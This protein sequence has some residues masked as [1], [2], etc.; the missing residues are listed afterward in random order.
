MEVVRFLPK[1]LSYLTNSKKVS[2]RE[3]GKVRYLSSWKVIEV[4]HLFLFQYFTRHK[5]KLELN[6]QVLKG[7][8]GNEY[9]YVLRYLIDI[10][11]IK[12][13]SKYIP[14][15]KSQSYVLRRNIRESEMIEAKVSKPKTAGKRINLPSNT[16]IPSEIREMLID[17]MSLMSIDYESAKKYLSENTKSERSYMKNL[18]C[19]EAIKSGELYYKFDKYGRMHTNFSILKKEIRQNYLYLGGEE[20][21]EIDLPNSQPLFLYKKIG[22]DGFYKWDRYDEDVLSGCFYENIQHQLNCDRRQAKQSVYHVLFGP[23]KN[24]LNHTVFKSLYPNVYQW[25]CDYKKATGKYK[26]LSHELQ[27]IESQFIYNTVIQ[28]IKE[29]RPHIPLITVHDS[30]LFPVSDKEYISDIFNTCT[31]DVF[32]VSLIL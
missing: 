4:I 15:E 23:T 29:E 27:R 25:I 24:D 7:L 18:Y 10:K 20:I 5:N 12:K 31:E 16:T 21:A 8:F 13:G 19:I 9:I 22:D 28:R 32:H 3:E 30:I 11:F 2:Y 14:R 1:K 26:I 6:S 17:D